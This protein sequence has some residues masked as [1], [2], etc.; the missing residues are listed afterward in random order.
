LAREAAERR[1]NQLE[2]KVDELTKQVER[3]LRGQNQTQEMLRKE[4]RKLEKDVAER[5]EKLAKQN[6]SLAWFRKKVYGSTSEK[7]GA[8][9]GKTKATKLKAKKGAN[10]KGQQ[11]GSKGHGRTDRS[12]V[13]V[14]DVTS[15][16]ID[17]C[18]C[19]HCGVLYKKL[20]TTEESVLFEYVEN[21]YQDIFERNKYV[22]Q[23]KCEGKK[24]VTAPP[25]PKLYP[26]TGIGNSLW[27]RL[28]VEKF[29]QG[30]P[31]NRTLKDLSLM[32]FALAQGTVTGG[33][34]IINQQLEPLYEGIANHCRAGDLW[35][36]DETSWRVFN[37]D[38]KKWWLWL[39]AS[40]DAVTYILDES[41]SGEVPNEFFAGCSG[42]L[43]TD[44]YSAY[45]GLQDGIRKAWCWVHVRRDFLQISQGMPNLKIWAN[46]WLK[47]I[48]QLFIFNHERFELW[49]IRQRAGNDWTKATEKIEKHLSKMEK[50]WQKELK[51]IGQPDERRTALNSLRR[52]WEG[53]T[54][55]LA[56]P[57]IPL[58]NNRAERLIRNPV[59][60]RKSSYGSGT[61]WSGRMAAKVFSIMQTWRINGLDPQKML[62]AYFDECSRTPGKAPSDISAYLPWTMSNEQ[63]R[64]AALPD[65]YSRPG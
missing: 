16:G 30:T 5:D 12:L 6:K 60:L 25:P 65:S 52:H 43:M 61:E 54:I 59:V 10:P 9:D 36:A 19:A 49:K 35:N 48:E 39:V 7:D 40:Q 17:N 21:L 32:G 29:L 55:F 63:K 27:V 26:R 2:A 38:R 45:K 46:S 47:R 4:I 28:I 11:P 15:L 33:F 20:E 53:L 56:D 64:E 13:P 51:E 3:L 58:H 41:R 18:K 42:A 23:C 50:C 8:V 24:I 44:R 37:G 57:R 34:K 1:C 31:T 62:R 14:G 22:S